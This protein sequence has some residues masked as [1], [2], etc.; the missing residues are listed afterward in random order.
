MTSGRISYFDMAR[1]KPERLLMAGIDYSLEKHVVY[2][3]AT[4]PRAGVRA[5]RPGRGKRSFTC[6]S[7]V[8]PLLRS[9]RFGSSTFS[10]ATTC[11]NMPSSISNDLLSSPFQKAKS[12]LL[13]EVHVPDKTTPAGFHGFIGRTEERYS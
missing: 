5:S 12:L 9:R 4:P 13:K 3:A 11:A 10:R 2:V 7:G 8:F 6:R 1:N